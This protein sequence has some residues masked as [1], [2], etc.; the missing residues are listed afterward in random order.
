MALAALMLFPVLA[1]MMLAAAPTA[2]DRAPLLAFS[3]PPQGAHIGGDYE[4]V[5]EADPSVS[6]ITFFYSPSGG[7]D[8]TAIGKGTHDI[9]FNYSL[10]W[11]TE[12]VQD[13]NY[14]LMVNG[15]VSGGG[16]TESTVAD[17]VVDNT[18][19]RPSFQSPL[20]GARL[21]GNVTVIVSSD[22]DTSSVDVYISTGGSPEVL[23]C[24][25]RAGG[26][27][28]WTMRW[29]TSSIERANDVTLIASAK[30][31]AG[32]EGTA[33]LLGIEVDNAPP[34]VELLSPTDD[35]TLT[36][37]VVLKARCADP[38]LMEVR[39]EWRVGQGTWLRVGTAAWNG[40]LAAF[41]LMWDLYNSSEYDRVEVR[42]VAVDDLGMQGMAVAVGL[43]IKDLP[44][45]PVIEAPMPGG[46]LTGAVVVVVA[47]DPDT[48][49]VDLS[50]G[51]SGDWTTIGAALRDADGK[52][53]CTWSTAPITMGEVTLRA[54]ATDLSGW[55]GEARL[56]DL[57]VDN[58]P[59]APWI[60][61]PAP[62]E[63]KIYPNYTLVATSDRDT[64]ALSFSYRAE[65]RWHLI[66][67]ASY[68]PDLERWVLL[69]NI[70][71]RIPDS[72]ICATAVDDVGLVGTY[73]V[74]D[75]DIDPGDR[76]PVF[77]AS[78]VASVS[79]DEDTEN[80]TDLG[81]YVDDDRPTEMRF[82]VSGPYRD[83]L[84][85]SGENKTGNLKMTMVSLPN[86]FGTVQVVVHVLDMSGQHAEA[87]LTV[88]VK[89]VHDPPFFE[90][91]PPNVYVHPGTEYPF[92]YGPYVSDPD[93][94]H[95]R[96]YIIPPS[97]PRVQRNETNPLGLVFL[98]GKE[99]LGKVMPVIV[100]ITD[101]PADGDNRASRTIIVTVTEDW[102]PELR[103]PLPDVTLNED[104][105]N[106]AVFNLDDYFFDRDKDTLYF[107][108]GNTHITVLIGS[109]YPHAVGIYIP[110]DWFG[111]DAVTFRATDPTGALL[112]D[113]IKIVVR[114]V[115]DPPQ[116]LDQPSIP[117]LTVH[118][119]VSYILELA[120]YVRDV[121]NDLT[122]LSLTTDDPA[123]ATRA[124]DP[125]YVLGLKLSYPLPRRTIHLKITVSDGVDSAWK[126]ITVNIG[127]T[128]PP[129]LR[130]APP[131]DIVLDEGGAYPQAFD[132]NS[133]YD[134][135][136]VGSSD[137]IWL[138]RFEIICWQGT[139][140]IGHADFVWRGGG[141]T[142]L[143]ADRPESGFVRFLMRL[144]GWIDVVLADPNWNTYNGTIDVPAA[145]M[146]RV[147]DIGGA[148]SE[149]SLLLHVLPVNDPPT[150]SPIPPIN[151]TGV[152][153][154]LLT[155]YIKDVDD[156]YAS[157]NIWVES[158]TQ[159]SGV[160]VH[161]WVYGELLYLDYTGTRPHTEALRLWVSD[162]EHIVNTTI[163]VNIK[164]VKEAKRQVPLILIVGL[165]AA[166]GGAA[167]YLSR[168]IWGRFEPPNVQDVFLVYGDGIILRHL[169]RRGAIGMDE[170]LAIAMLT[171]IQEFVQ[172]SMR[173]AQLK[174]MQ[175]GDSNILIERDRKRNFYIAVIHT[176]SVSEG[177]RRAVN[178][179][180]RAVH[181]KFG[182]LLERW[183][184]NLAKFDGVEELLQD[185]LVITHAH[186]PEGVRFEMEGITSIEPGKTFLLQGKD[187]M[188]T[189]NIFRSLVEEHGGGLLI[190][191]V[192]PQRLHPGI[193]KAGAECVWLSKT[194]T[195]RG[196]SPSNTTMILHE[197]STYVRDHSGTVVCLDGLEYLTVHSPVEEVVK[198]LNEL[199]DMAQVDGFIMM[200]HVDPTS[201]DVATLSKLSRD[202]VRVSE[203][204]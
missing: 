85:V 140:T 36:G 35:A 42:A 135:D 46:H 92:D 168:Y 191:R 47:S 158:L 97:D 182:K 76:A 88:T 59:P 176:G 160:G 144:N 75:I 5:A 4:L 24:C 103:R 56:S 119:N 62:G 20:G 126:S 79:F 69:C 200:V 125:G 117:E 104:E 137:D 84:Q 9:A 133:V 16:S 192:H 110:Q 53:R 23:G 13:G 86:K 81:P 196:V 99:D 128:Y 83:L 40:T 6:N 129:L 173:S 204:R 27:D 54:V 106:R 26:T 55:T 114:P 80:T 122:S 154:L 162:G 95:S 19:P 49:H 116:F 131:S 201:L 31:E 187:V 72:A 68:D 15:T 50:Y 112:E 71:T 132:M 138:L 172:Q 186:I 57:E 146:I 78:M 157:L 44:P 41:A 195:K 120:P 60:L 170:D 167:L 153:G 48:L 142:D 67:N 66:G 127:D 91:V 139:Q 141:W 63:F 156:S 163:T 98:Y 111:E 107:S 185:I 1:A 150:V 143:L 96:L 89:E 155:N 73:E 180:T 188:R 190:S 70:Q 52:W 2:A 94:P 177:L 45:V 109:A 28:N 61:R 113:T 22:P 43:K 30:D 34:E 29:D 105:S 37:R 77:K 17:I 32:N 149:Y 164:A 124:L 90:S 7:P 161:A 159:P 18:V 100:T 197:I 39:F 148:F 65:G 166:S 199:T 51:R 169:S 202:M 115:N 184:G 12:L 171:A 118:H 134:Q 87:N 151:V 136:W 165:I 38:H 178:D 174:S 130:A 8:W 21:H 108:Y 203:D 121:D 179:A 82:Y 93:T 64:V 147:K 152:L 10:L 11:D 181:E 25:S 145:V 14:T 175:A 3:S 183:D 33:F 189:H 193:A 194:P 198:F 58:T 74:A 102:V 123:H 101:G